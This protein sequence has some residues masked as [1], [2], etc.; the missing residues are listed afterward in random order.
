MTI[1]IT[2]NEYN[3]I[4][5][6]FEELPSVVLDAEDHKFLQHNAN[7]SIA[8]SLKRIADSFETLLE[9]KKA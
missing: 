2:D 8:I 6:R 9:M 7:V 1:K 3:N 4:I 5:D